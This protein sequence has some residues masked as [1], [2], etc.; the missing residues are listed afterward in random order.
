[1]SAVLA[2]AAAAVPF[3]TNAAPGEAAAQA[4]LTCTNNHW[5]RDVSDA[6]KIVGVGPSTSGFQL[7]DDVAGYPVGHIFTLCTNPANRVHYL[8]NQIPA[9]GTPNG[10]PWVGVTVGQHYAITAA[11]TGPGPHEAFT[12]VCTGSHQERIHW[13]FQGD[14]TFTIATTPPTLWTSPPSFG[15]PGT[16]YNISGMC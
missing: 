6:N 2:F 5:I 7:E 9:G 4:G 8:Q 13:A 3:A 14:D 10:K 16:V 11:A 15:L 1:M 12:I